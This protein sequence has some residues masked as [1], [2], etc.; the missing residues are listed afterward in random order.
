M[1]NAD[2]AAALH[3]PDDCDDE[4]IVDQAFV[5]DAVTDVEPSKSPQPSSIC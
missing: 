2:L 1:V 3:L 5:N 4:V